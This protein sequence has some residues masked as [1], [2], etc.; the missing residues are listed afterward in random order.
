MIFLVSVASCALDEE[1][2]ARIFRSDQIYERFVVPHGYPRF[3]I[4]SNRVEIVTG[5]HGRL[6]R[7]PIFAIDGPVRVANLLARDIRLL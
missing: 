5:R 1:T 7:E 2:V 4:H 6:V 3:Q